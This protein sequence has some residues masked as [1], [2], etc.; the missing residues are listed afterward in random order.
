MLLVVMNP[1]WLTNPSPTAVA[2]L[3]HQYITKSA[4]SGTTG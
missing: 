3:C 2:A 1:N 4:L